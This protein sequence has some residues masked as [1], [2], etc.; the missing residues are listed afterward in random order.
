MPGGKSRLPKYP[1]CLVNIEDE[2]GRS[3]G[4]LIREDG[5]RLQ[6]QRSR[7]GI[8]IMMCKGTALGLGSNVSINLIK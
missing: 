5:G 7:V 1:S 4:G 8:Y 2:T 3:I 6:S